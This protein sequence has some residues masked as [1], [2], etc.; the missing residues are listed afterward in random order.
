MV[1]VGVKVCKEGTPRW[2][3]CVWG[4]RGKW[5]VWWQAK[6][7]CRGQGVCVVCNKGVV[8]WCVCVCVWYK[9]NP[10]VCV[11]GV[12]RGKGGGGVCGGGVNQN[13][14]QLIN[15]TCPATTVCV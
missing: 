1:V 4:K 14:Q 6:G 8:L 3:V 11:V 12:V 7:V 5:G 13:M 9:P 2:C 15:Q 10:C